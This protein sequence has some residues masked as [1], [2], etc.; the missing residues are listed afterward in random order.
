MSE[1]Q[2]HIMGPAQSKESLRLSIRVNIDSKIWI[3]GSYGPYIWD[4]IDLPWQPFNRATVMKD[5]T[6]LKQ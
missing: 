3:S 4:F 5:I 6:Q 1:R 2:L